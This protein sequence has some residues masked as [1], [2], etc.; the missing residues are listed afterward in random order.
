[1]KLPATD[2]LVASFTHIAKPLIQAQ[3][4][5]YACDNREVKVEVGEEEVS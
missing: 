2:P 3:T 4:A 1:M 5:V